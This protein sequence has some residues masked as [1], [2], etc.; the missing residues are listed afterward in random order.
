[1]TYNVFSGTL[2]LLSQSR[3]KIQGLETL[4]RR[5]LINDLVLYYKIWSGHCYLVLNVAPS[6]CVTGG[7]NFKLFKPR[8]SI[9]VRIFLSTHGTVY[10]ILFYLHHQLVILKRNFV[11]LILIDFLTIVE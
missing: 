5:R 3:L 2:N 8:C 4:E 9:D 11:R 10:L 1:M 6:S 7:N